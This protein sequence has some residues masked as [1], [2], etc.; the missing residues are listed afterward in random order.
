MDIM[1]EIEKTILEESAGRETYCFFADPAEHS[2]S[3]LIYNTGFKCLN[4]DKVYFGF[5]VPEGMIG[6]AMTLVRE[7]NIKGVNISMPHKQSVIHHLDNIDKNAKFCGAVNTIVNNGGI[8]TGYNTD[9]IGAVKSLKVLGADIKGGNVVLLGLGGA[10][11][12]ILTGLCREGAALVSVFVREANEKKHREYAEAISRAFPGVVVQICNFDN[13][14]M[15]KERI[16]EAETLINATSVGMGELAEKSPVQEV[17]F[18]HE[19]LIVMDAI[20]SPKV[21]KLLKQAQE[22]GARAFVNG[23]EMLVY[24]AEA[25]FRLYTG[26]EMPTAKIKYL[27]K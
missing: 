2:L 16:G 11:Q 21:T 9:S 10:G 4:M 8:L 24:Q 7:L 5:R 19:N 23:I 6:N 18:L 25:A 15:L 1:K 13:K 14:E 27:F 12:A 26:E 20:Y 17:S 3:P 22:A